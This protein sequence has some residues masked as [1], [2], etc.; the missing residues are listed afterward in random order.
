MRTT[1]TVAIKVLVRLSPLHLQA[2]E[3]A[4]A[5]M[6]RL[7][8]NDEREP[9]SEGSEHVCMQWNMEKAIL[10]IGSDKMT[11]KYDYDKPLTVRFPDR[12]EWKGGLTTDRKG[13]LIGYTD[14]SKTS[15]CTGAGV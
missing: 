15:K 13:L 5:G 12:C 4:E 6:C 11:P 10:Q 14:G 3:E 9:K 7:C 2:E 8:C 1:P